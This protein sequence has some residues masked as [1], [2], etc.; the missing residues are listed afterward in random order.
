MLIPEAP[1]NSEE[2]DHWERS[3]TLLDEGVFATGFG[4]PVVPQ[5]QARI[6]TQMSAAHT[7]EQLDRAVRAVFDSWNTDRARIYR[8]RERIPHDLGTAVNVCT[9]VFG[10]LGSDSGTGVAFTRDPASGAQGIYG[11][12]EASRL[13]FAKEPQELSVAEMAIVFSHE[14]FSVVP[15]KVP[16]GA[17]KR[18]MSRS[19]ILSNTYS[20]KAPLASLTVCVPSA[21]TRRGPRSTRR[22]PSTAAR[23]RSARTLTSTTCGSESISSRTARGLLCTIDPFRR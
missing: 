10:N 5:G 22:A 11:V 14:P 16:S 6:R 7:R 21:K 19:F 23:D 9:M 17:S 4:F 13:Y 8:R 2:H 12:W 18:R 1:R 20:V 3:W 15:V